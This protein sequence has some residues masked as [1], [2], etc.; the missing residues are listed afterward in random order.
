M[1]RN[2]GN[3]FLKIARNFSYYFV[4]SNYRFLIRHTQIC[5]DLLVFSLRFVS[6]LCQS[7][8]SSDVYRLSP[9]ILDPT[10]CFYLKKLLYDINL[11][12]IDVVPSY[13]V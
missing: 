1:R 5:F 9:V 7:D 13:V 12:D 2:H 10:L 6:W 3:S 4:E 11:K 8:G